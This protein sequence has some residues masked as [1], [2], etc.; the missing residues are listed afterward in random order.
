MVTLEDIADNQ[1]VFQRHLL[2]YLEIIEVVRLQFV[3]KRFGPPIDDESCWKILSVRDFQVNAKSAPEYN[4]HTKSFDHL[5][6]QKKYKNTYQKWSEWQHQTC[7]AIEPSHI[8]R[9][10]DL[11]SRCKTTLRKQNLSNIL[12]SFMPPPNREFFER[13]ADR[14]LPSSLLAF[15]AIHGGQ[16]PLTP[17]SSDDEFF[18]GL[19]G[20]YSCYDSFY[21]MRL[22]HVNESIIESVSSSSRWIVGVNLGNP[23]IILVLDFHK[24]EEPDGSMYAHFGHSG[25][26][27]L[28]LVCRGGLLSYFETY[29][30]RLE[31]SVYTGRII[32]PDSPSSMGLSLFPETGDM[33]SVAISHGVEVRASAR[34]FPEFFHG[35]MNFGYSIR[36]RLAEGDSENGEVSCQLVS[37]NWEFR[38]EDG[39]INRVQGEGAVGKQ[40]LLFRRRDGTSGFVDLGPAGNGETNINTAFKYESQSGPVPGTSS[41]DV[42]KTMNVRVRGTFTFRPGSIDSPTG[43]TFLV[44]VAEFPLRVSLPFY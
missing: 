19:F 29:V 33:V 22:V 38:Y 8:T 6:E 34:W 4:P 3:S 16:S 30:E 2:P 14:K 25:M 23:R 17:R 9:A 18:A 26:H 28:H 39:T 20:S 40:P 21:S 10:I 12:D 1:D 13:A 44:T 7:F 11:W 41:N 37:R 43:T 5:R 36:I 27:D 24:G 15:Y 31:N 35:P 32:H 42:T